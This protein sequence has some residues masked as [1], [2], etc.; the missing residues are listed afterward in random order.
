MAHLENKLEW[1]LKKAKKEGDKHRGLREV[2]PDIEKANKHIDKAN[3]NLK[4]MIHLTKGK[5]PDWAVSASFYS[6]YHCL[7]AILAKYGYE[8]RNQECTFVAVEHLIKIRKVDLDIGWLRRIASFNENLDKDD[9]ITLREKFQYGT[10][11]VVDNS[12]IN[13]LLNDTKEFIQ[14]VKMVLKK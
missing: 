7:L 3:H 6:M 11:A 1:C 14:I 9:I 4:A 13:D 5:F 12:K 2:Q 10:E 8:S